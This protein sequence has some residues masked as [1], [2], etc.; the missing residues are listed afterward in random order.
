VEAI[1]ELKNPQP[2][3]FVQQANIGKAVQVN[4]STAIN[5]SNSHAREKI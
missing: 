1:G 4:N 3:S 2:F 5:P